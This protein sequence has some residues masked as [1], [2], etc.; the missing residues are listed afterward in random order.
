MSEDEK[1]FNEIV[2]KLKS[3]VE[4]SDRLKMAVGSCYGDSS[5]DIRTAMHE[6]DETMYVDKRD[7]YRKHN[8][9]NVRN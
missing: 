5:M 3:E 1:Q 8:I 4:K 6:A 9:K 7:Y 2:D